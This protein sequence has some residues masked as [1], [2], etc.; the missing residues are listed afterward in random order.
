MV[1]RRR[2]E[3][4]VDAR[5][6]SL[7]RFVVRLV[8]AASQYDNRTGRWRRIRLYAIR[9]TV[10]PRDPREVVVRLERAACS[11]QTV[12]SSEDVAVRDRRDRPM[13]GQ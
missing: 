6:A 11:R 3:A 10:P 4:T 13:R 9:A 7:F 5:S 1:R 2:Q 8:H 12:C